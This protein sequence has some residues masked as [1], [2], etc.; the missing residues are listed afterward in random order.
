MLN[1]RNFLKTAAAAP[2]LLRAA[3]ANDRIR[4]AI[5]GVNSRGFSLMK[6][7]LTMGADNVEVAALCDVD[8]VVLAKRAKEF[9]KL[10]GGK[11][12]A[13]EADM[14]TLIGDKS[15]DAIIHSTPTN[16]HATGGIWTMQAGKDAYIEKPLALTLWEGQQ[17]VR[18]ARKYNRIVQHGTQCRSSPEILE[19]MALLK[20][21]IIGDVYLAR[22]MGHKYRPGIGPIAPGTAPATLNYDMWRG[23]AA[24]KPYSANQIHYNWHWFWDTGNGDLGNLAVHGLD[25]M[26]MALGL[27]GELP[28]RV[29]SMGGNLLFDDC[30]ETPNFQT[31][32]FKYRK[33]KMM[34]EYSIRNGYTNS[35]GGM[36]E[37]IPFT[38][39]DKRDS[40]SLIVYGSEGYMLLPDYISYYVH[41]GRDRK[42]VKKLVGSGP[43]D[44]NEPHLRN[45]LKAMRSRRSADLNAE[46]ELGSQSAAMCHFANIAYRA[47]RTLAVDAKGSIVGDAA[48]AAMATRTYRKAYAVPLTV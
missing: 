45:F 38:M 11:K 24:M 17:I 37:A 7:L 2:A 26:R 19:A 9:E 8:S 47:G 21:G 22:G 44:S 42:L 25:V 1:R 27:D 41:I 16:W 15:I 35:E 32:V 33:K 43:P 39:G 5:I 40:H 10:S 36:G 6:S 18:A 31:S 48:A 34:L 46:C 28:E 3:G 13:T 14:R 12:V 30:K 4:V 20:Q 23:P 29:Q